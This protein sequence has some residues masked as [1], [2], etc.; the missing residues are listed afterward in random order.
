MNQISR[1][2]TLSSPAPGLL[3]SL[4]EVSRFLGVA[5]NT[6]NQWRC[7]RKGPPFVKLGTG[8]VR[9]RGEDLLAWIASLPGETS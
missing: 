8:I 6:L 1:P 5:K 4:D 2:E 7:Q 9:Y 3:Y